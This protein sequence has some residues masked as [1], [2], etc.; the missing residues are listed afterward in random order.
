MRFRY[1][2]VLLSWSR[3][4]MWEKLMRCRSVPRISVGMEMRKTHP[5]WVQTSLPSRLTAVKHTYLSH[6]FLTQVLLSVLVQRGKL[7]LCFYDSKDSSLH[8]MTDTPDN[9]KLHL[10][11]RGKYY[12]RHFTVHIFRWKDALLFFILF[13]KGDAQLLMVCTSFSITVI[14]SFNLVLQEVSPHVIITSAK[15]EH[16]MTRFL[17][18]LGEFLGT[19]IICKWRQGRQK[20]PRLC[21]K[22]WV[23]GIEWDCGCLTLH[24]TNLIMGRSVSPIYYAL[25]YPVFPERN[26]AMRNN[27]MPSTFLLF[28]SVKSWLQTRSGYLSLCRL[29]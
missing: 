19:H 15:Q 26:S 24:T 3:H 16:C 28:P 25:P 2:S 7:G 14:S 11:A 27:H 22:M 5:W 21:F 23:K 9:Y 8:C 17:Q 20:T 10:L 1:S 29:W 18:Q 13:F 12:A 4:K 6:I